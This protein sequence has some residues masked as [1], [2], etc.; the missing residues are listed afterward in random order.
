MIATSI[1]PVMVAANAVANSNK[2]VGS[3]TEFSNRDYLIMFLTALWT[4]IVPTIA[5]CLTDNIGILVGSFIVG[6]LPDLVVLAIIL[7]KT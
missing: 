2:G 5:C 6:L 1:L 4:I 3:E 7:Q